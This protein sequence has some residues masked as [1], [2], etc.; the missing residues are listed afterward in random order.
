MTDTQITDLRKAFQVTFAL[1]PFLI[2]L[3]ID[4]RKTIP[5]IDNSN[6][7]FTEDALTG[8]QST[9]ASILPTY[10]NVAEMALDLSLFKQLDEFVL[11]AND[12]SEQ[13]RDT[14]MLAG[15]EAYISGLTIYRL[16][17]AGAN[18]GIPGADTFYKQ[19]QERFKG[20]GG[21]GTSVNPPA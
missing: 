7:T 2:G 14:Q 20:Q 15:S 4:E 11:L 3:T 8:A 18:A 6:K 1:L 19:L 5:K 13:L 16:S 21:S 17:E 10:V 9:Y 12:L